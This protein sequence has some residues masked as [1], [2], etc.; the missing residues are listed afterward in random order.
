IWQPFG[1]IA[2][3]VAWGPLTWLTEGARMFSQMP[4]AATQLP[5]FPLWMLLLYYAVVVGGWWW[6]VSAKLVQGD[7]T[8]ASDSPPSVAAVQV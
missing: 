3:L 6:I 1:Q 8:I 2:A 4:G 7:A 5:P